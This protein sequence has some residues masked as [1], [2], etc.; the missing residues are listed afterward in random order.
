MLTGK[1]LFFIG[2]VAAVALVAV[3]VACCRPEPGKAERNA[4]GLERG[5]ESKPPS[6]PPDGKAPV[7][8]AATPKTEGERV[9]LS[10]GGGLFVLG[11]LD[12]DGNF[13]RDENE[14]PFRLRE[15]YPL[16]GPRIVTEDQV[17]KVIEPPAGEDPK[18]K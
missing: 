10:R 6:P 13:T 5:H 1:R 17:K 15:R 8:P 16:G 4:N 9:V 3:I 2:G 7:S 14:K 12:A 11:W 18:G